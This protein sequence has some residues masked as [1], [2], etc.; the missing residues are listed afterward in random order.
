MQD[1]LLL[2]S[3]QRRGLG[4]KL[5]KVILEEY[6]DLRQIILLT[7]DTEKQKVSI[8]KMDLTRLV[9]IIS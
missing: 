2:E 4:S 1:I 3:Y 5:L 7:D 8:R 9:S 6:K